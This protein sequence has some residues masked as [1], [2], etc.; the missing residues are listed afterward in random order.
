M[1][2]S[3][4]ALL[5]CILALRAQCAVLKTYDLQ[6]Q[7][8]YACPN[9]TELTCVVLWRLNPRNGLTGTSENFYRLQCTETPQIDVKCNLPKMFTFT[10]AKLV[11]PISASNHMSED[12]M[13]RYI[14]NGDFLRIGC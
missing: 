3:R 6:S 10:T 9:S 5:V 4:I 7:M 12:Q 11:K 13:A 14:D 2:Y 8:I 1:L